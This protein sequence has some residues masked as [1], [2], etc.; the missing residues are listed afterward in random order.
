MA[1]SRVRERWAVGWRD[2]GTDGRMDGGTEGWRE[3]RL[4]DNMG[5]QQPQNITNEQ[6]KAK[7]NIE[8]RINNNVCAISICNLERL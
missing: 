7:S 8:R 2:G 5:T 3:Q 4:G 6:T 1:Q